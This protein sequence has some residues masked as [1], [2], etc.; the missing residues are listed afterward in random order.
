MCDTGGDVETRDHATQVFTVI[1]SSGNRCPDCRMQP[2]GAGQYASSASQYAGAGAADTHIGGRRAN[3]ASGANRGPGL[4]VQRGADA[5]RSGQGR[6][7]A[8]CG[9]AASKE[10]VGDD[11]L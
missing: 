1:S 3:S 11:R 2:L 6:Q 7:V 10:S 4:T 8:A 9:S 5:G